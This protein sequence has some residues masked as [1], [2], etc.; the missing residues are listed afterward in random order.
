M[1]IKI[2]CHFLETCE[3]LTNSKSIILSDE[4]T[5]TTSTLPIINSF[6]VNNAMDNDNS[7]KTPDLVNAPLSEG[8]KQILV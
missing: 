4:K 2:C 5:Q 1:Y 7:T 6:E 8:I 3:H